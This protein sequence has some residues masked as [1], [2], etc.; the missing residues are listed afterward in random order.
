QL[1]IPLRLPNPGLR[2]SSAHCP[3][4]ASTRGVFATKRS[5]SMNKRSIIVGLICALSAPLLLPLDASARPHPGMGCGPTQAAADAGGAP[6][7][8][9][10]EHRM[11][12]PPYLRGVQLTD[13]QR[14]QI[15]EIW[16]A[17]RDQVCQRVQTLRQAH[18][19]LQ[20]VARA[21]QFDAARAKEIA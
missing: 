6:P 16:Q 18:K 1:Y 19:A 4:H 11:H 15:R 20:D 9:A 5:S 13:N 8:G 2:V 3:H 7:P 14:A 21:P 10:G 12:K 17:Q